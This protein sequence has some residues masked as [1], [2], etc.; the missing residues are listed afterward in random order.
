MMN[1]TIDEGNLRFTFS[2]D[3]MSALRFDNLVIDGLKA[4]DFVAETTD[5]LYFIEIKDF[6]NPKATPE[7]RKSDA[8]ML[9]AAITEKKP[10]LTLRW[11]KR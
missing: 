7:R 11:V 3:Y 10:H 8:D 5:L 9:K 4:I 6:Q 2:K 1:K